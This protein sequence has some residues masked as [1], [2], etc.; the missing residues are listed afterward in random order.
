[1]GDG[2]GGPASFA[3]RRPCESA[4]QATAAAL[5]HCQA[6]PG[7]PSVQ[8]DVEHAGG[9]KGCRLFQAL[10]SQ[11]VHV[12]VQVRDLRLFDELRDDVGALGRN[13]ACDATPPQAGEPAAPCPLGQLPSHACLRIHARADSLPI[14]QLACLRCCCRRKARAGRKRCPG[15]AQKKQASAHARR[16]LEGGREHLLL[17]RSRR[18]ILHL[19]FSSASH[20]AATPASPSSLPFRLRSVTESF[21]SSAS[22]I[23]FAP[24]S[25]R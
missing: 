9:Q 5:P 22:A 10:V 4:R 14:C 8:S 3:G 12:Q 7:E 1:M 24:S 16:R 13:A 11:V 25:P 6:W 15:R 17:P 21:S 18:C 2:G 20:T 19:R 23:S